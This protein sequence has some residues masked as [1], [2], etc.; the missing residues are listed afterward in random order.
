MKKILFVCTGNICRSPT[1]E[2]V[3]RQL[4]SARSIAL[5]IDSAGT[6]NWHAGEGIDA[7]AAAAANRRGY[8]TA[9]IRA[10]GL[11]TGDFMHFDIIYGMTRQHCDDM[12][13]AV[14]QHALPA[15]SADKIKLFLADTTGQDA[16]VPDPYYGEDDGFE[17]M[18]D[19][20][21]QGCRNIITQL[22]K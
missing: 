13:V 14:R 10:R 12:Q 4:A 22:T 6:G 9:A 2:A 20:I 16:D 17:H 7:R 11:T 3:L 8:D 15:D 18:F 5:E 21:E 19:L 1:A